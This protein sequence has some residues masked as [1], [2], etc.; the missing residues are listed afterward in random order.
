MFPAFIFFF[1]EYLLR[2][3][4]IKFLLRIKVYIITIKNILYIINNYY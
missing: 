3:L 1:K 2:S 4:I